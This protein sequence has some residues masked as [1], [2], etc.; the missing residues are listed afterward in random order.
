MPVPAEVPNAVH[1]S[2]LYGN[3]RGRCDGYA[4]R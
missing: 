2:H 1:G 4:T 3:R